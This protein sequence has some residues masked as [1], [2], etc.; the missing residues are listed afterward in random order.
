MTKSP[1]N[2]LGQQ[3]KLSHL[4]RDPQSQHGFV[5]PPVYH[6]STVLYPTVAS[7]ETRNQPYSYGR[8][9][10]PTIEALETALAELEGGA[11]TVLTPSGLAAIT[12]AFLSVVNAGDH[13]LVTDSVYRPTRHFCD[14][15]L[16]RLGVE[17]TYYDPL[18]GSGIDALIRDNTRLVYV[19]SPGSQTFEMQDLP[20]IS[21]AA[22]MRD[23]LVFFD[24]TWGTPL[25]CQ[26]F[27]LG[28]DIS[29]Q[30]AT[31]YIIGHADAML[32]VVT[33]NEKTASALRNLH[34]TL[35]LCA[36]PDDVYLGLRGMR[37]MAV[38]LNRHSASALTM[39]N[40]LR[41]RDEVA[42]V[43]HPALEDDPG[44]AIWKR[45]FTGS[46]GLFSVVLKPCS[47]DAIAAMLDDLALFGMGFSWGGFESLV[48]PF[49]P[50]AYR[51]ATRW[52]A[53][54]PALRFHIGLE[55]VADLQ[56][57]LDAGFARLRAIG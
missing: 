19:E 9:G 21:E 22:H 15:V 54:G 20:A 12:T 41:E 31:K 33:A 51:S 40:W 49:D 7:L 4:G 46:S 53:E 27:A 11:R 18:I 24:N 28:A 52:D 55:D 48:I 23:A 38:R 30:A 26:P 37:T 35:G 6:G 32:G 43:L 10:T 29:I 34:G 44:H 3:T 39:A 25:F 16:T 57:D 13:I 56:T 17:T 42:R 1:A 5:N 45:D 36:G 14:T 2:T 47:K 50:S 8:R